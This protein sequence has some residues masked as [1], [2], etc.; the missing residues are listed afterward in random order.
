MVSC[1]FKIQTN[2]NFIFA[3]YYV[4][5]IYPRYKCR[6]DVDLLKQNPPHE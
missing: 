6:T 5:D 3:Q 2:G 4:F 1:F